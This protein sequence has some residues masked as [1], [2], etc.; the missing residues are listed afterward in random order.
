MFLAYIDRSVSSFLWGYLFFWVV[1]L[2]IGTGVGAYFIAVALTKR[3]VRHKRAEDI[4]KRKYHIDNIDITR[5][6][7]FADLPNNYVVVS[8]KTIGEDYINSEIVE[9]GAVK[10]VDGVAKKQFS[11][12]ICPNIKVNPSSLVGTGISC[13]ELESKPDIDTVMPD[14]EA[15]IDED[16]IV[17]CGEK[18]LMILVANAERYL[19]NKS[20]DILMMAKEFYPE[21]ERYRL[22]DIAKYLG[23]EYKIVQSSV[24]Q[25]YTILKCYERMSKMSTTENL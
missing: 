25:C 10:V 18:D 4:A 7:S 23:V 12:I 21:I 16:T 6:T 5:I 8:L 19:D 11:H 17:V 1:I 2:A 20:V 13:K 15:F 14:L 24:E 3:K 9:I 22:K